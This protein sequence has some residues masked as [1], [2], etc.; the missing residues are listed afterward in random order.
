MDGCSWSKDICPEVYVVWL[1]PSVH[2]NLYSV[3][4]VVILEY[5]MK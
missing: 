3:R 2:W 5:H 1:V 4:T